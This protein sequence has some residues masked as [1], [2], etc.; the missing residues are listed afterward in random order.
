MNR[1]F[2]FRGGELGV[3]E[4][5]A[6]ELGDELRIFLKYSTTQLLTTHLLISHFS[7]LN[8]T[9]PLQLQDPPAL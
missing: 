6:E 4:L 5:G 8:S 1:L 2:L 7:I 9:T 3:E